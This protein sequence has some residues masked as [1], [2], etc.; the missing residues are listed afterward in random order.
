MNALCMER[1]GVDK[2]KAIISDFGVDWAD[3]S[4]TCVIV[5]ASNRQ[6]AD[7]MNSKPDPQIAEPSAGY[8]QPLEQAADVRAVPLPLTAQQQDHLREAMVDFEELEA[9][10]I[11]KNLPAPAPAAKK[12]AL[13][14]LHT[15]VREVS[16]PYAVCMWD[17]GVV[18]VY[19]Q[20][21]EGSRVSVYFEADGSAMCLVTSR[22]PEHSEEREF[23]PEETAACEWVF[24]ALRKLGA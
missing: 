6:G 11:E 18:V 12:A 10:A 8:A 24:D 3:R 19:T 5:A 16:R 20:S 17:D 4:A 15:A 2:N 23:S 21:A 22:K 13:A 7:M 1:G 9:D 14:F